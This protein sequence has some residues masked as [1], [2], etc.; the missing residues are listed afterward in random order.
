MMT[1]PIPGRLR[2]GRV[3]VV[4]AQAGFAAFAF[5]E[6]T[7]AFQPLFK[8]AI[9]RRSL[10]A[11]VTRMWLYI[12]RR[13]SMRECMTALAGRRKLHLPRFTSTM[14]RLAGMYRSVGNRRN[15]HQYRSDPPR[16]VGEILNFLRLER[17]AE[18]VVLS[19]GEPF[20]EDL[21]AAELVTPDGG[22]D[23]A[24]PSASV[25]VDVEGGAA[26]D[27][28]CIV[29]GGPFVRGMCALDDAALAGHDRIA[30]PKVP[31]AG[32]EREVVA[33]HV[34]TVDGGGNRNGRD[35]RAK[36]ALG[37]A[38]DWCVRIEEPWQVPAS[39]GRSGKRRRGAVGVTLRPT[40]KRDA[41]PFHLERAGVGRAVGGIVEGGEDMV[42]EVFDGLAQPIEVPCGW[43]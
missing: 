21:V 40:G 32:G 6:N 38:G 5:A 43:R 19:V 36:G 1:I 22:G 31:P 28:A 39:R 12:L 16:G 29:E 11:R 15:G 17:T 14:N 9:A 34:A 2:N 18:D 42:E 37:D 10:T 27:G 33:R 8:Q 25:Q 23:V 13:R 30:L 41:G 3:G 35:F 24:P 20:L 4:K 26:E 7:I